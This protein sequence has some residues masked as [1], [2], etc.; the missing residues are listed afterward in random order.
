M[1]LSVTQ[2]K[3]CMYL[4]FGRETV[5][6]AGVFLVNIFL[7]TSIIMVKVIILDLDKFHDPSSSPN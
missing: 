3:I 7:V 4:I 5:H 2:G 6:T 1:Q